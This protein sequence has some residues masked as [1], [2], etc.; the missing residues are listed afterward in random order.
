MKMR[1]LYLGSEDS[2]SHAAAK[3]MFRFSK[4]SEIPSDELV[5]VK[6][7]DEVFDKLEK[8]EAH[9][10]VIPIENSLVGDINLNFNR[11]F[12]TDVCIIRELYLKINHNLLIYP[13]SKVSNIK[14]IFI[15]PEI[16]QLCKKFLENHQEWE[17]I[18]TESTSD[19]ARLIKNEQLIDSAT[20]ASTYASEL[21]NLKIA[22]QSIADDSKNYTRF[23]VITKELFDFPPF[24]ADKCS[25]I[26]ELP[27]SLGALQNSL[28]TLS[29]GGAN[30]TKIES[31]SISKN[32]KVYRFYIDFL[33]ENGLNLGGFEKVTNNLRVLGFYKAGKHVEES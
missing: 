31:R 6:S 14:K 29:D 25:L 26:F 9:M 7:I 27:H 16:R 17:E 10:A 32:P 24:D 19:A 1:V 18:I 2:H 8:F 4:S 11:F 15:H 3:M 28:Q 21:Y 23:V 13:D 33:F 5:P 30:I 20:I 12:T 22:K